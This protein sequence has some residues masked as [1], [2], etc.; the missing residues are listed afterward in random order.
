MSLS[1]D[2]GVWALLMGL[3]D[4]VGKL[5]SAEFFLFTFTLASHLEFIRNAARK[6]A[7]KGNLHGGLSLYP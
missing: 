1:E 2:L 4:S 7:R 5:V 6:H 3:V